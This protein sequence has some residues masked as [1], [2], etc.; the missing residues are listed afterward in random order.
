MTTTTTTMTTT[1]TTTT[2]VANGEPTRGATA[3][4]KKPQSLQLTP[5]Y[6]SDDNDNDN[7]NDN[8]DNDDNYTPVTVASVSRPPAGPSPSASACRWPPGSWTAAQRTS[9]P[10]TSA[11]PPPNRIMK[12]TV[13]I[14]D[15]SC[16]RHFG[17]KKF[18]TIPHH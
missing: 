4:F 18:G 2:M 7:D 13:R 12:Y 5:T 16:I 9:Q 8:D 17:K 1:T 10:E 11:S 14:I 3:G 15:D 6:S